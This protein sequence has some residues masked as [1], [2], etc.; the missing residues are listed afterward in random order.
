MLE[1]QNRHHQKLIDQ[2]DRDGHDDRQG[3]TYPEVVNQGIKTHKNSKNR[4]ENVECLQDFLNQ[5]IVEIAG[6]MEKLAKGIQFLTPVLRH[7]EDKSQYGQHH[8]QK[9]KDSHNRSSRISSPSI[10][11]SCKSHFLFLLCLY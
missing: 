4:Q 8:R 10:I 1:K 7:D 9:Q 6:I 11:T 3:Q 5:Q 2:T